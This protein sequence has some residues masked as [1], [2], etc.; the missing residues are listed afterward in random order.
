MEYGQ[1]PDEKINWENC[2]CLQCVVVGDY[3]NGA[4]NLIILFIHFIFNKKFTICSTN[5]VQC[6]VFTVFT[7]NGRKRLKFCFLSVQSIFETFLS[8]PPFHLKRNECADINK[9]SINF[10]S[11][12]I[13][14]AF[15]LLVDI[16]WGTRKSLSRDSQYFDFYIFA[17]TFC[18]NN[19]V[20]AR[21]NEREKKEMTKCVLT[22]A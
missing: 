15:I 7:D 13:V 18:Y 1:K 6:S 17:C 20:R 19:F 9:I 2:K 3:S 4:F 8:I 16:K 14:T 10:W 5:N 21:W 12:H 22:S 11:N